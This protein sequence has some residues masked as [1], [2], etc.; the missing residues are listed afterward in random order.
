MSKG[1]KDYY[2]ILGV[3]KDA[4]EEEIKKAY[5][6]LALKWH[7]DKNPDNREQAQKN[8]QE[9]AEAYSTLSDKD[10]RRKYDLGGPENF[11]IGFT[12]FGSGFNFA[13]AEE[14]F[15]NFFGDDDPFS[16]FEDDFFGG[17]LFGHHGKAKN[18]EPNVRRANTH[19]LFANPFK[20]DPFFEDDF[21][22]FSGFGEH[23]YE[24]FEPSGQSSSVEKTTVIKNGKAVT[25]TKT[26]TIGPDGEK[27][28]KVVEE[29]KEKG[30]KPHSIKS[31]EEAEAPKHLKAKED[32]K[33]KDLL[34]EKISIKKPKEKAK[35][36]T[37]IT[38]A[39]SKNLY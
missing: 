16:M 17:G 35:K 10:K 2:E 19:N 12:R 36:T 3:G 26:V 11:D 34:H 13:A 39:K 24:S 32:R 20:K 23:D 5:K 38:R 27:V 33:V 37:K 8:F 7:P 29:V 18:R 1:K 4:T 21:F 31:F 28:V 6:K 9:I 15:R 14:I 30:G 25:R 22:G